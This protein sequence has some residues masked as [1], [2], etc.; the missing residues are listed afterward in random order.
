MAT[1][2]TRILVGTDLSARSDRA[3][4]R[5]FQLGNTLGVPVE[6]LM[7]L[8]DA[9]PEDLRAPLHEKAVQ[10]LEALCTRWSG[11]CPFTVNVQPGDPTEALVQAATT[12]STLIVM[13]PHR[14]RPFLDVLRETTMQTVVR[15]TAAP[16]LLVTEPVTGPYRHILSLIDFNEAA[17]NAMKLGASLSEGAQIK[18]C[19]AVHIPYSG[20]I[21]TTGAVQLELQQSLVEDAER[22]GKRWHDA[23]G[24]LKGRL[25]AM[26]VE[27]APPNGVVRAATESRSFDLLTA[28]A[29]GKVGASRSLLGSVATDLMRSPPCDVLI[30][31]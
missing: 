29:H 4:E 27:S 12:P 30:S 25:E 1:P 8:D 22:E 14:P 23:Q 10:Q 26:E 9:M 18:P 24:A 13:G 16:V 6:A 28:G 31:R 7:I 11:G 21:E 19:H 15:Q 17:D 20:S 5:A 2:L 3:L